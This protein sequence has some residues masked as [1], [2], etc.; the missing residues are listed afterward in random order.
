MSS[1]V[2]DASAVLAIMHREKGYEKALQHLEGACIS[3]VNYSEVLKKA[4]EAGSDLIA[5]RFHL[6]NFALT[7]VPFDERQ[8]ARAAELWPA[9]RAHGLSF[10]DR[11]CLALGLERKAK[12]LT[13]DKRWKDTGLD[14]AVMLF[15]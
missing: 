4:I 1:V 5:T 2:F 15:R 8:A 11:A 13:G 10:A 9:G 3:A 14:V 6:E 12:V 7:I